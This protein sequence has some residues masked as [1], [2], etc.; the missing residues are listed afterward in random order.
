MSVRDLQAAAL[1]MAGVLV[2]AWITGASA[3]RVAIAQLSGQR[4]LATSEAALKLLDYAASPMADIYAA[5]SKLQQ[6]DL[7]TMDD[8]AR[9]LAVAA[10]I[11]AARIGGDVAG[12]CRELSESA[13]QFGS[14][15]VSFV[16]I[17]V[18]RAGQIGRKVAELMDAY[19]KYRQS[20][21]DKILTAGAK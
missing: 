4:Q 8:A 11:G 15:P 17:K 20:L 14:I 10:A 1:G 16:Q 13:N 18:D 12:R 7:K 3:E 19:D 2:G 6:Y 21:Q 9:Q 5:N